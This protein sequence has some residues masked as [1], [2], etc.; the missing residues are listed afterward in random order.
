[1]GFGMRQRKEGTDAHFHP[2][3]EAL[4]H[5]G[6]MLPRTPRAARSFW[7]KCAGFRGES[8]N[9]GIVSTLDLRSPAGGIARKRAE[10]LFGLV[11]RC[12]FGQEGHRSRCSCPGP[13]LGHDDQLLAR[14]IAAA[15]LAVSADRSSS[16]AALVVPAIWASLFRLVMSVL[17][18]SHRHS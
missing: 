6:P 9:S 17:C 7:R 16:F 4:F 5:P 3:S 1:M 8:G 14:P 2:E 18:C 11:A 13:S 12:V 10:C 15:I